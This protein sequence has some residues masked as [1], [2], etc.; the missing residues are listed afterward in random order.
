MKYLAVS[1]TTLAASL[2]YER[3]VL[4]RS[5]FMLV[6]LVVFVQLWTSTYAATGESII[7]GLSLRDLVWYLVV[8]ETVALSTPRVAQT[9]D[10]EVRA[11]DVAYRLSR[12]I[13]YPLYHLAGYWGETAGR[14]PVNVAVGCLVALVAVGPPDVSVASLVATLVGICA[15]VTMKGLVEVLIGLTAF[16]VEETAPIEWIYAKFVMTLGGLFIPLEMFPDWLAA[17]S[18]VLPFAVVAY[19]PAR[20]FVGFSVSTAVPVLLLQLLW[21]A[22]AFALVSLVFD[23]ATRRVVAHGG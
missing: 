6:A 3:D 1:R 11:G 14:I 18:A 13:S 5:I 12:P 16:W 21:L 23:R 22:I 17:I 10:A 7:G 9:I 20:L 8:T 2:M 19:A 15:A 4:V